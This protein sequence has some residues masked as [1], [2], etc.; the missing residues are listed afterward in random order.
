MLEHLPGVERE[1]KASKGRSQVR[2]DVGLFSG[3]SDLVLFSE[4]DGHNVHLAADVAIILNFTVLILG[5]QREPEL[6]S[7]F[8]IPL[9]LV[10]LFFVQ[11]VLVVVVLVNGE[12][13]VGGGAVEESLLQIHLVGANNL[14]GR[15]EVAIVALHGEVV[16]LS[17]VFDLVLEPVVERANTV[18]VTPV[19]IGL[20]GIFL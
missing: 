16:I 1:R 19:S 10:R 17:G 11:Q 7:F 9:Q 14:V 5:S 4:R 18:L 8:L 3:G 6:L 12:G 13:S 2:T 20:K 15:E